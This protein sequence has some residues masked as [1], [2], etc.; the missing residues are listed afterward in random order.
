MAN[1][2]LMMEQENITPRFEFRCFGQNIKPFA[3]KMH[4]MADAPETKESKEVYIL[5]HRGNRI[6][7]KVRDEQIDMKELIGVE[8]GLEQ[9]TVK[10]K[11]SLPVSREFLEDDILPL[12]GV[13][14]SLRQE[15]Y[16]IEEL[17]DKV[18][19]LSPELVAVHVHKR[20]KIFHIDGCIAEY[21]DI[22]ANGALIH[23]IC[24]ESESTRD[25]L[26]LIGKL[27]LKNHENTSYLGALKRITG[28]VPLNRIPELPPE[29]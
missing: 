9:W 15:E 25:T 12:L 18:I 10:L 26:D 21:A 16:D 6:N 8:E 7:C 5:S 3:V 13:R 11:E 22:L 20:R 1:E 23:S 17:V 19:P 29:E 27:G 14:L 4:S 2:I 28:M 24:V